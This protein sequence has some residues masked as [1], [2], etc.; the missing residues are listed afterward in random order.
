MVNKICILLFNFSLCGYTLTAQ[1]DEPVSAADSLLNKIDSLKEISPGIEF[2]S[3][4][5]NKIVFWG[6]DFGRP[7]FGFENNVTFKNGK[8][9]YL[10]YTSYI[11]SSMPNPYAK[12]DIGVGYER[13]FTDRFYASVGYE[14]WFF[15]NGDD[16]V[17]KALVNYTEAEM[18]FD[19]DWITFESSFYYMNGLENIFQADINVIKEIF[20]FSFSRSGNVS[21]QPQFL[22]TFANQAFL[23]IYSN[24]PTGFINEKKF[25]PLDFELSIPFS[26]KV[27]NLE[28]APNFHYNIPVKIGNEQISS[29]FYFSCRLS[30]NFYFTKGK[31]KKLYSY[32]K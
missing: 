11:W 13:Q 5:A 28:I 7:Q 4:F 25:K 27:R 26:V 23:P 31:L 10:S 30:Y 18:N 29:F 9:F 15:N 8:G 16:Y 3:D 24:Y 21:M 2:S 17:K 12:T 32:L 6:R 19:F 1:N 20:L 14:R 22:T